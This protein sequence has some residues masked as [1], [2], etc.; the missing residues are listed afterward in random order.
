MKNLKYALL[1]VG[2]FAFAGCEYKTDS[3][4]NASSIKST[5]EASKC[6]SG[7]C[8]KDM[9]CSGDMKCGKDKKCGSGKCGK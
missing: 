4:T 2:V 8:G 3:A 9:K 7:K 5:K 6:G 1:F